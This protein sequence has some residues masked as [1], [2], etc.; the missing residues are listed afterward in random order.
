MHSG[1]NN[2]N[3]LGEEMYALIAR[4]FPICR[5][6]TGDGLRETLRI[7]R[8]SIPIEIHDV[9]TGT[10]VFDWI[11]PR[12]WNIRD[13]SIKD[14]A[15][16]RVVDF[17]QSNLH[18]VNGSVPIRRRMRWDDLKPHLTTLPEHPEWIP[19]RTA[20]FQERWGFCLTQRSFDELD[21]LGNR[22]YD[23]CID[24]SLEDGSLTYGELLL[25]GRTSHEILIST[26]IC[27]PSLANDGLSGI[28]V[29]A[30]LA[31]T[32][33]DCERRY[34]Y[35]FLFAPATIGAITWLSLNEERTGNIQHGMVLSCLGDRGCTTYRR[36]R[37]HT[38]E[39]DRAFEH[40]L[41]HS[42]QDYEILDF[43]P[44]GY[45][46]RQFCSPGFD[47]PVGCLM[48]TPNEQYPEYHTSADNLDL[49]RPGPLADSLSKVLQVCRLLERNRF[50]IN[51]K[52]K[53]EPRL[54]SS[55]L[56]DAYGSQSDR[57]Q[58]QQAVLWTLNLSDGKHSLLDVAERSGMPFDVIERAALK[59]DQ[60]GFLKRQRDEGERQLVETSPMPLSVLH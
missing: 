19:Y 29:A 59:L 24:S 37:R 47:L 9:P 51:V 52:P 8:E 55:G 2:P 50:Y 16:R 5:S 54:G 27:H 33:I 12:E 10:P 23:V 40:I 4:L 35:R 42:H 22:E 31:Q 1:K 44:F 34:S 18:V 14:D 38:A 32:L 48:R 11:V 49:V 30:F 46:Q 26:H 41:R 45:D 58:L 43:E 15:G 53:C 13:A 17:R 7:L 20:F 39:I 25:P 6:N 60:H 28:A 3:D 57:A 56:Y 21:R 36:S